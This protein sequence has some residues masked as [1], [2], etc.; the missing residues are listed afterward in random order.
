MSGDK[1]SKL[2]KF[3]S[4]VP[5][6]LGVLVEKGSSGMSQGRGLSE[7]VSAVNAS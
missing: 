4:W 5:W 2:A 3:F 6:T 1:I 7:K